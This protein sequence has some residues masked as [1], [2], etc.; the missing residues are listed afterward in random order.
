MNKRGQ[1]YLITVLVIAAAAFTITAKTNT[2]EESILFEDFTPLSQNYISES[3]KVINYALENE[4]GEFIEEK[5]ENFTRAFL[6][7]A[8][9][10]DST[11][12]LVYIYSNGSDVFISNFLDN[13]TIDYQNETTYPAGQ[14]LLQD[15]S[16]EVGGKEFTHQTPT[17]IEDFGKSWYTYGGGTP[18]QMNISLGGIAH[19]FD[20]ASGPDFKVIIRSSSGDVRELTLGG[21]SGEWTPRSKSSET[22][23]NLL[24]SIIQVIK[25]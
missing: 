11:V 24:K 21:G 15:I 5:L 2:L 8:K 16:L 25:Y 7:Y 13:T 10:R 12:E 23:G 18:E 14:E 20:L 4:E 1:F 6:E 3:T 17:A 9:Q 19:N 22:F